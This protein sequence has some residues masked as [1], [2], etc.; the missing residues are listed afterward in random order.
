MFRVGAGLP[1][2]ARPARASRF[3][4]GTAFVVALAV[5]GSAAAA[6]SCRE[7]RTAPVSRC[8]GSS[9]SDARGS[10]D[11]IRRGRKLRVVPDLLADFL[12]AD[13]CIDPKTG[14]PTGYAD[15][16][17]RASAGDIAQHLIINVAKLDWRMTREHEIRPRL[18]DGIWESL[19][20]EILGWDVAGRATL[21]AAFSE[22]SFLP[23]GPCPPT[24][25]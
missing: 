18:L 9:S 12:I 21:L 22:V 23:T 10:W 20:E 11:S 5:G 8:I 1:G 7:R 2:P 13:A 24:R 14:S 19:S 17:F 16:V 6:S 3:G 25:G 15:R 4:A